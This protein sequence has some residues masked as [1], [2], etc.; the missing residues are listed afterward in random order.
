M[1]PTVPGQ[2]F[3]KKAYKKFCKN[4][5]NILTAVIKSP[6]EGR[7]W[8]PHRAFFFCFIRTVLGLGETPYFFKDLMV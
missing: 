8:S 4:L 2:L 1:K 5:T 6:T 3:I 7:W